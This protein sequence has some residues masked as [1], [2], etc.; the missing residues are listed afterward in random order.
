MNNVQRP[1][2]GTKSQFSCSTSS[3]VLCHKNKA[4]TFEAKILETKGLFSEILVLPQQEEVH[5]KSDQRIEE[6][7]ELSVLKL[8]SQS[9]SCG[10]NCSRFPCKLF[11]GP[12]ANFKHGHQSSNKNKSF[13]GAVLKCTPTSN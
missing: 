7:H 1:T 6:N 2:T 8:D 13:V 5:E 10:I 11:S 4:V 9:V 3:R 12:T